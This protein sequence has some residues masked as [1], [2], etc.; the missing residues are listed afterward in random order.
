[1]SYLPA[2]VAGR[3]FCLCLIL[4]P[5]SRKIVGCEVHES[6]SSD[7]AAHLAKRT[8]LAE[9]VHALAAGFASSPP[10]NVTR[11]RITPSWLRV[12]RCTSRR[13]TSIG[14]AGL[15]IPVTGLRWQP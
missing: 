11:G 4:D 13:A 7:H 10:R 5:Y 1:M 2:A 12:M 9:G 8:A 14:A 6:D 3:W 15:G